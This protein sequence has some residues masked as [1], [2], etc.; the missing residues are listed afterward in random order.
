[1]S[2]VWTRLS[3]RAFEVG[4]LLKG[5]DGLLELLGGCA[6]LLTNQ[7]AIRRAVAWLTRTELLE[8]PHD[9]VANHLIVL[10]RHLS[11]GTQHFASAYLIAHGTI[12]L[13]LVIG[14]LRGVRGAY[15]VALMV[16][17]AFIGYQCYRLAHGSSAA[18][19][20]FTAIDIVV[21]LLIARG[22]RLRRH[23]GDQPLVAPPSRR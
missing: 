2:A 21:V 23:W 16:L 4:I 8:D 10:A 5:L 1:M 11:I 20:L 19:L 17:T 6:L 15:P 3:H 9:F 13:G 7:H 12:K 18:L 14:L 22:W